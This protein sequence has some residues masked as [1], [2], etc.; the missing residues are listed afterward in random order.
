MYTWRAI[1]NPTILLN[2]LEQFVE[3]PQSIGL[4]EERNK[5]NTVNEHNFH[6]FT[7]IH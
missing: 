3:M 7:L 1:N 5:Q 6:F 2:I 4:D